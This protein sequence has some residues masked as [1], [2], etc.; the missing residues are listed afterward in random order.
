MRCGHETI[1]PQTRVRL[2]IK[3][4]FA[5]SRN[6]ILS[7]PHAHI[8]YSLQELVSKEPHKNLTPHILAMVL[9][10]VAVSKT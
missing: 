9:R 7:I 4:T 1:W 8:K 2:F 5:F 10:W 6:K 3:I